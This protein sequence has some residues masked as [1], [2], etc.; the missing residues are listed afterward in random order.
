MQKSCHVRSLGNHAGLGKSVFARKQE[1]IDRLVGGQNKI[2]GTFTVSS[3]LCI[4][5]RHKSVTPLKYESLSSVN[6]DTKNSKETHKG[7]THRMDNK[8]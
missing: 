6:I 1:A 3:F 2:G 4:L 5:L 7:R 8:K